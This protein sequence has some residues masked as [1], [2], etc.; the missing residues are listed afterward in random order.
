MSAAFKQ[1]IENI[2]D[3]S[4]DERA[5]VA[6]CLI[7]SLEL[8]QDEGVDEAWAEL[9]EKRLMEL[10]SGEV[11]GVSWGDIKNKVKGQDG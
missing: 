11:K 10:K 9:S 5:L 2:K 6:H 4:P 8:R 7:S 3:L 1:V